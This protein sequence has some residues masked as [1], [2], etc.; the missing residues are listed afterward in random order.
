MLN[1]ESEHVLEFLDGG[2]H[3]GLGVD[4]GG[5]EPFGDNFSL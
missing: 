2:L 1:I 4:L 5:D 3:G